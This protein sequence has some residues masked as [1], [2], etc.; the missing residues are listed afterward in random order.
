MAAATGLAWPGAPWLA[1]ADP[2]LS[3]A[4]YLR[5][6]GRAQALRKDGLVAALTT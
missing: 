2:L 4:D 5:A 1:T 6:L 3:R